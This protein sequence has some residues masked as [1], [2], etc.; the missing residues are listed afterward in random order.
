MMFGFIPRATKAFRVWDP[1]PI[2]VEITAE[3][4][5]LRVE[6]EPDVCGFSACMVAVTWPQYFCG[7]GH[8]AAWQRE[9]WRLTA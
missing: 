7:D 5:L 8:H 9:H 6:P 1:N 2:P 3:D 4:V